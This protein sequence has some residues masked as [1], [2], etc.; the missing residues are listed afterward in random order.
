MTKSS[1]GR[2]FQRIFSLRMLGWIVIGLAMV[3]TNTGCA[4]LTLATLGS[5]LGTAGSAA[6]AGQEVYNL[7]KLDAAEMARFD[8]A[9]LATHQAADD[10]TLQF[11]PNPKSH[12]KDPAV[13]ELP[14]TDDK[15][16]KIN[17]RIERRAER[18]VWIRIDVGWF[19]SE[20]TAHLFLT[21]LRAHLPR[22]NPPNRPEPEQA[23]LL[24]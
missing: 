23:S 20:V 13:V 18:L 14:F 24:Q 3:F 17:V 9:V 19:G 7:G 21:R 11:K 8:Q 16:D 2:W 5:I 22:P 1:S 4:T 15:K 6:S 12:Q 10:L